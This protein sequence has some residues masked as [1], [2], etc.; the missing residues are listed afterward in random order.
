MTQDHTGVEPIEKS[1]IFPSSNRPVDLPTRFGPFLLREVLGSG[2]MGIVYRALRVDS[3]QSLALKMIHPQHATLENRRRFR[4]EIEA[5]TKLD[6]EGIAPIFE[7]G[8]I[9][10]TLFYTTKFL[11][12]GDLTSRARPMSPYEAARIVG[13]V[14]NAVHH[15]HTNGIL[16]RDLKPGNIVFDTSGKPHV[17]DFGLAKIRANDQ[18]LTRTGVALG[19]PNYMAP[20]LVADSSRFTG[21]EVDV[22]SLGVVLFECLV[23]RLPGTALGHGVERH[24]SFDDP[25]ALRQF[26]PAT[27]TAL[28]LICLKSIAPNPIDRYPSA[29]ALANDLE[30][31]QAG[32]PISVKPRGWFDRKIQW[33]RRNAALVTAVLVTSLAVLF[34]GIGL[35]FAWLWRSAERE[36][37]VAKIARDDAIAARHEAE[38]ERKQI[39]ISEYGR[40][41]QVAYQEWKD[42]HVSAARSILER[43][44]PEYRG[45][46]WR[47]VH[48]LCHAELRTHNPEA[49]P[50]ASL[51][52]HPNGELV[53]VACDDGCIR[54]WDVITG[55]LRRTIPGHNG[56][57]LAVAFSPDGHHLA[58]ASYDGT[59]RLVA[60][61]HRATADILIHSRPVRGLA[62]SR[63]GTRLATACDDGVFRVWN[64]SDHSEFCSFSYGEPEPR[65]VAFHRDGAHLL[66]GGGLAESRIWNITSR[67]ET[68]RLFEGSTLQSGL[69][70]PDGS[71]LITSSHNGV[72]KIW[73]TATRVPIHVLKGHRDMT[74]C[75]AFSRD[76]SL[77]AT[78]GNDKTARIWDVRT[79][80]CLA[81]LK[82]HTA[83]VRSVAFSPDGTR[84]A[85]ASDDGT[86]K[87]WSTRQTDV[88]ARVLGSR[89]SQPL[90]S[91]VL[92][93]DGRLVATAHRDRSVKLWDA[94]TGRMIRDF[95]DYPAG[96]ESIVF[97]PDGRSILTGCYDGTIQL[98]E[99][100]S[101]STHLKLTDGPGQRRWGAFVDV[102]RDGTRIA[103]IGPGGVV[104]IF[105]SV[106][107]NP[108]CELPSETPW[109]ITACFSPNGKQILT[110]GCDDAARI[111][112]I[113][114]RKVKVT[115]RGNGPEFFWASYNSDG[116]KVVTGCRDSIA[117]I[118]D[119]KS[120][121]R[122]CE[123]RGHSDRII[124]AAFLPNESRVVTSS[125][126]GTVKIWDE[127]SGAELLTLKGHVGP[128]HQVSCSRD[129]HRIISAGGDGSARIWDDRRDPD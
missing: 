114:T 48:R 25:R 24:A 21:P 96:V 90:M 105:D 97:R 89:N 28:R 22:Y 88:E 116:T 41:I 110:S 45:W 4:T 93:H 15:A 81:V 26:L 123:L 19:T 72:P 2:G 17:T 68:G 92:S 8:E 83:G 86:W 119:A 11:E 106:T 34:L 112:D 63:D 60:W 74:Y 42:D 128:V 107:Q 80:E 70:S 79:G 78:G 38:I 124:S 18:K 53:A 23:G 51:A 120:G 54:L 111:W 82:G 36:A 9:E 32:R 118:W 55:E 52:Y 91:A 73:N 101:G 7:S 12:G 27:P 46:E 3:N 75:A 129:G 66:T 100:E 20:E 40:S 31:F 14:A 104:G 44:Q 69:F 43:T 71:L 57:V 5:A 108:Q 94:D 50:L 16:H 99:I 35:T 62:F 64:L 115:L 10:G 67:T 127:E 65:S 77:V 85:T 39:S 125:G 87:L 13:L 103:T 121:Q 113:E 6:H 122:L 59:V 126:D 84:I 98:R 49:G 95:Q 33:C 30:E 1:G 47:Y 58:S 109:V 76:G 37:A 117:T 56:P 29:Q 61:N 102:N